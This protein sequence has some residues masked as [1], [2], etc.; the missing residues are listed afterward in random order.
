MRAKIEVKIYIHD[1]SRLT[2][3]CDTVS[4]NGPLK[5][6]T[7]FGCSS[8]IIAMAWQLY[9]GMHAR[10]PNGKEFSKLLDVTLSSI[11]RF[12]HAHGCFFRTVILLLNL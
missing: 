11:M 4:R 7:K 12:C 3:A 5:I 2:K 10:I 9:D 1:E 6:I 8:R